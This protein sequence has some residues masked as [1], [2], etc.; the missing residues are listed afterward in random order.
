MNKSP[1]SCIKLREMR[2]INC[3]IIITT[4]LFSSITTTF[5]TT[6]QPAAAKKDYKPGILSVAYFIESANNSI[7]SLSSRFFSSPRISAKPCLS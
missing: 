6:A 5:V 1:A 3:H 7:N 4:F 2:S